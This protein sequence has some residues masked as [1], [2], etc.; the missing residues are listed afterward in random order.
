MSN[1]QT[2]SAQVEKY[3]DVLPELAPLYQDHWEELALDREHYEAAL[4]PRWEDYR[5]MDAA[6]ELLVV[7]LRERG[8]LAGYFL[9]LIRPHL[10][11]GL[12]LTCTM[13]IYRVLPEYRGRHG[14]VRLFRAVE[15]E[16][17]RRGVKRMFMGSKLHK[18][19]SRLFVALG[20]T[21]VEVY[22]SKWIGD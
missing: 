1:R 8:V 11:Y 3:S 2:L 21:P 14:G 15:A 10:H 9:G 6:G 17:R 13:D 5:R 19:T 22:H 16:C 7:T 4:A 12:C 20:F 18:D